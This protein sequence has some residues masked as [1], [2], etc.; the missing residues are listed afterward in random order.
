MNEQII[1]ELSDFLKN[2]PTAFHAVETI[3][4]ILNK[5]GYTCLSEADKFKIVPGGKYYITRNRSS[6]IAF[7]ISE[8]VEDYSFRIMASHS[9]SP[10][11]KIKEKSELVVKDH[12][13][14]LN[15]EG[16]G[17]MICSTWFDRP[18]SVAGRVMVQNGDNIETKLIR[19]N[20]DLCMIPSLAIHMDRNVNE[21]HSFNKQVDMLPLI[22]SEQFTDGSLYKLIAEECGIDF[23]SIVSADLYLYNRME[24]T[25]WGAQNEYFSA[26]KLDDLQC[27]YAT[28]KGFIKSTPVCGVNV[29]V[30]FDNE[31]VGSTTK[32]GAVSTFMSD[33]LWR[34]NSSLAKNDE[35]YFRAMAESFMISC[36]NAHAVH[37]N[38]PDKTDQN[39][40]A[41]LNGGIVIKSHAGQKYTSD[42]VS[43]AIFKSICKK[44]GVPFQYFAN[45]SDMAGGSTLGNLAMTHVSV[46][47]LDVGLPQLSMHSSYE[48]CGVNDTCYLVDASKT[49]YSSK[50]TS[51]RDGDYSII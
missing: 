21:G 26:P 24:A 7:N 51:E 34:I 2:S 8:N 40:C 50:I 9:D 32:Q 23:G 11:F 6:I 36:D 38:Y 41:Y 18:L 17:G 35:D 49:F 47:A 31:E 5:E 12:Y 3:S 16:Y 14:K 48:T 28:L 13:S 39:N 20:R 1:K 29:F 25:V 42:G 43:I 37:P 33:V 46:N 44:S 15:T 4:N 22:G 30:C 27:A 45:R 19:L 10:T